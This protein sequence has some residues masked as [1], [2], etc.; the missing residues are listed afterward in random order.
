[1]AF[2]FYHSLL[3]T[4]RELTE[5]AGCPA[6]L[7]LAEVLEA[8]GA[9]RHPGAGVEHHDVRLR[10]LVLRG[11]GRGHRRRRA[12][13]GP[14]P[15]R[16][17]VVHRRRRRA[18]QR[19]GHGGRRRD[20]AGPGAALRPAGLPAHRGLGGEV[21]VRA[22]RVPGRGAVVDADPPA[23]GPPGAAPGGPPRP[24]AER[25]AQ[26]LAAGRDDRPGPRAEPAAAASAGGRDRVLDR[27]WTGLVAVVALGLLYVLARFMFG[28]GLGIAGGQLLAPNPNLN[29]L[30]T[31]ELGAQFAAA[32]W[33]RAPTRRCTSR[34]CAP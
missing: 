15:A 4:P 28:P 34:R 21:Q 17:G 27:A 9:L 22:V 1:M 29:P 12:R 10:G 3:T 32:G 7:G 8:G 5:A 31:P 14:V 33:P 24:L 16:G 18:G 23:A 19:G 20:P 30:L 11:S 2:S 26:A 13:P 25:L 6:P